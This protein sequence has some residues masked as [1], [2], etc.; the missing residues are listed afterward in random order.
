MI[1]AT[2]ELAALRLRSP[3]SRFLRFTLAAARFSLARS[4]GGQMREGGMRYGRKHG[5]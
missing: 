3:A 5:A 1:V 2:E 4:R